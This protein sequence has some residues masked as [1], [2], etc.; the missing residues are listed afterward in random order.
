VADAAKLGSVKFRQSPSA[1]GSRLVLRSTTSAW[2]LSRVTPAKPEL[3][4]DSIPAGNY[5]VDY[6]RDS[7]GDGL[8]HPGSLAPW[9]IQ[10]PFF[11]FAD[12]VDV[13]AGG[14]NRGD[15]S[16]KRTAASDP[17]PAPGSSLPAP[18]SVSAPERMLS[19]PPGG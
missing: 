12:S 6:F 9:A 8:W 16:K 19:W 17:G 14:T 18:D 7:D 10:E 11:Q 13:K 1:Y 3:I 5:A 4:L 2:E 15:G